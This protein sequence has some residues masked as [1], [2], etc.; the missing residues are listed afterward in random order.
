M[1]P[2]FPVEKVVK[3]VL[4]PV[5]YNPLGDYFMGIA[6]RLPSG[7][8]QQWARENIKSA[9]LSEDILSQVLVEANGRIELVRESWADYWKDFLALLPTHFGDLLDR[10][11]TTHRG[12]IKSRFDQACAI[13]YCFSYFSLLKN[14]LEHIEAIKDNSFRRLLLQKVFGFECFAVKWAVGH[15][16]LS[17]G[18]STV[19]NPCYLLS[20][21]RQPRAYDDPKFLPLITVPGK[22]ESPSL[23]YYYRQY[24]IDKQHAISLLLYPAVSIGRR[25]AS[26]ELLEYLTPGVSAK[27]DP[28][29]RQRSK[30][31]TDLAVA[32]FLSSYFNVQEASQNKEISFVDIGGGTGSL[33]SSICKKLLKTM[34]GLLKNRKFTCSI[35]DLRLQQPSR[36]FRRG[37]LRRTVSYLTYEQADYLDWLQHQEI[38]PGKYEFDVALICR[39][40]N[41]LSS[42][43]IDSSDSWHVVKRLGGKRF[44]KPNWVDRD[45]DPVKCLNPC[46]ERTDKLIASNSQVLLDT[47]KTFRQLSLSEYYKGLSC[48]LGS[49]KANPNSDPV[50]FPLRQFNTQCLVLPDGS[51][52][53]EKLCGVAKL[54][55]IED[56]DIS[57]RHLHDH[58]KKLRLEHLVASDVSGRTQKHSARLFC[59]CGKE[60]S[61]HIPG[62][63]I[64]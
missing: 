40:F 24:K 51:S 21:I 12:L 23:F 28:R 57:D 20:K 25:A 1:P 34:P 19:R 13:K 39:L 35:V 15:E 37:Q 14:I 63:R 10:L 32:P 44:Q 33:A 50:H 36:Y 29:S 2:P 46:T 54:V 42:F 17:A 31:I 56:I 27:P 43:R 45:F 59:L 8:D 48:L 49:S 5:E 47:G 58:L 22:A 55:V 6:I 3:P 11:R 60:F 7:L 53:I 61:S 30:T 16:G 4:N 18:T 64:W 9:L 52:A 62:R 26:F 38:L 41:N